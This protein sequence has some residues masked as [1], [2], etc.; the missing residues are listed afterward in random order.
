MGEAVKEAV[1][2]VKK[3]MRTDG[4]GGGGGGVVDE[5]RVLLKIPGEE[6]C[7]WVWVGHIFFF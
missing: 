2:R 5:E 4:E 6:V 7:V 3:K 1:G